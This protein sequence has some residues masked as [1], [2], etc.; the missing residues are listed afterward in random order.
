MKR[1]YLR[2]F[3]LFL[4]L[5]GVSANA[6]QKFKTTPGSVIGYLEY[7]PPDYNSSSAN[8]PV[9]IFLHGK[10]EKGPNSR[11]PKQLEHGVNELTKHGPPKHVKNGTQFPFILISPQ[12]KAGVNGW[13]P[14]YVMEVID[15]VLNTLRIDRSRIYLTGMSMGGFGTWMLAQTYPDF[16]AAIAPVCG[17]GNPAKAK[18]IADANLP[19]W[20][21]HGDAD[22][23]VPASRSIAMVNAV[24]AHKPRTEAKISI[25]RGVKH[26]S[27]ENAY[28]PGH[29][30]HNP[31]VYEW[32]L[33][34]RK[35][36]SQPQETPPPVVVAGEDKVV[37]LPSNAIIL[38][39]SAK[40]PSGSI[41]SV[42]WE[43][44]SGPS[45]T[46]E[47]DKTTRLSLT[48]LLEGVYEFRFSAIDDKGKASSDLVKV[49]V[50]KAATPETPVVSAGDDRAITLPTQS[51]TLQGNVTST[52][53]VKTMEW[54][55]VSGGAATLHDAN[56]NT[57]R[58]TDL[59]EGQYVFRLLA[60]SEQGAAGHDDVQVTVRKAEVQNQ[61]P[62]V[63][64]GA[65]IKVVL[66][67]STVTLSGTA[68]DP[69]GNI[70]SY[71]W[72][73]VSGPAVKINDAGKPSAYITE[74]VE[75]TYT[76]R[77]TVIDDNGGVA[78]DNVIV[79][80]QP[81][82]ST[83]PFDNLAYAG[84]DQTVKFPLDEVLLEGVARDSSVPGL[85]FEWKQLAGPRANIKGEKKA[86]AVVTDISSP[87]V[88]IFQLAVTDPDRGVDVDEVRI[89]VTEGRHKMIDPDG[90]SDEAVSIDPA[91]L[92]LAHP[93]EERF[94]DLSVVVFND[95][96]E[97]IYA[98]PWKEDS[99]QE[100][101]V[102][103][104][105]YIYHIVQG[106]RRLDVGK[107]IITQ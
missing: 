8:F 34:H 50:L 79:G 23:I 14:D 91:E 20:A 48:N 72:T 100:V 75:G 76:F 86:H 1:L 15:H 55:K 56:T 22:R 10:G 62:Q 59:A 33:T 40:S 51:I 88:L 53:G 102:T 57:L 24:N 82:P 37:R 4:C 64:A 2:F 19:V 89:Y 80:I 46:Q 68:S 98:G 30:I 25:Y 52:S 106:D 49:S 9:V 32:L 41:K 63:N 93:D 43:K 60:T 104:G 78:T 18:D 74:F 81:P 12:L 11:D 47:G 83:V 85:T 77:L 26:D 45:V 31:N 90:S 67:I 5:C 58:V 7:L 73:K 92:D 84:E 70:V 105:F 66:P 96:G 65:D 97:K 101:F 87:G 17:G 61:S 54:S 38:E 27:W 107:L 42:A 99:Y 95:R 71:E 39:G 36:G 44:I 13:R 16:F 3:C 69:D 35:N 94:K 28:Q 29:S 6:Q 103:H 21:F